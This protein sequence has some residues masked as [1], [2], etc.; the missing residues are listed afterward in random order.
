MKSGPI[1]LVKFWN[2]EILNFKFAILSNTIQ[3]IEFIN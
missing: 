2:F 3:V 1:D